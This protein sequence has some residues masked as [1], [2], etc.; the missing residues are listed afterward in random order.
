MRAADAGTVNKVGRLRTLPSTLVYSALVGESGVTTFTGPLRSPLCITWRIT[1]ITSSNE[2]H[3]QYCP[4]DPI[5][6][7]PPS[8][9][10][11]SVAPSAP[12]SV[13]STMPSLGCTTRTPP[14]EPDPPP[15][16]TPG[17]PPRGRDPPTRSP[18]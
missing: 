11:G 2:T 16:P 6:P 8:L 18:P 5:F 15:P 13:L 12:P 3:D 14:R 9:N 4:P 17:K 10:M 1:P 7:P